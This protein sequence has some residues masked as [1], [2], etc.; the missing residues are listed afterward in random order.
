MS[1]IFANGE[2]YIFRKRSPINFCFTKLES[3][4]IQKHFVHPR[5]GKLLNILRRDIHTRL[6]RI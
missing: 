5:T 3:T 4:K 1:L 2:I 6:T